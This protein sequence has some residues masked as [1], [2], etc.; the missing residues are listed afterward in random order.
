MYSF[1]YSLFILLLLSCLFLWN[2][3]K[4]NEDTLLRESCLQNLNNLRGLFALEIVMGHVVRYENTILLPLGKFMICS[5]AF[6]YFVSAF[7]MAVSF[8]KKKDYLNL[9]FLLSKPVYLFFLA[10]IFFVT[11]MVVDTLCPNDLSYITSGIPSAFLFTT[12]WYIWELI[13]FYIV[14]FLIYKFIPKFRVFLFGIITI[15]LSV[16][17]YQHG[18]WEAYVASTFAFPAGL[19]CGEHFSQV[20]KF[21]YSSKGVF[22]AMILAIFGLCCLLIK[23]EN[24]IS[25]IFMRNSLCLAVI[26]IMLYFCNYFTLGSNPVARFLCRYSTEI[27]LS[28]FICIRM[29]ESYKWNYMIRMPFVLVFTI[30]LAV[31][32][33]P[34]VVMLKALLS[35]KQN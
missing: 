6:F 4:R 18:F 17:M 23:P 34:L 24:M 29:A 7:G 25:M 31:I 19:L 14:Y 8:E 1:I 28:Q 35:Y 3:K 15:I 26:M 9:G 22:T 20:T 5:V 16:V 27:Y 2:C 12:N 33:H 30:I 13:G 21:L 32:L 11:G 10:V